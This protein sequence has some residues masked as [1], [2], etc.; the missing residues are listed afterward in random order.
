M[1][2]ISTVNTTPLPQPST[3][4]RHLR[5]ALCLNAAWNIVNFRSGLVRALMREG[6]EVVALAPPDDFVPQLLALGVAYVPITLD[7]KGTNP[8]LE[9]RSLLQLRSALREVKPDVYLGYTPKP[10]IYGAITCRS[11]GIPS[12]VNIAGLG[13]MFD[14]QGFRAR[15]MRF[16]YRLALQRCHLIFFQ[17]TDDKELFLRWKVAKPGVTAGLPGSGVDLA[18]FQHQP[19][20]PHR[21]PFIFL[22]VARLLWSKGLAELVEASR[23]LKAAGHAVECQV[24]GPIDHGSPDAVPESTIRAWHDEGLIRYLGSASDVRPHLTQAHA[25]VLPSYYKEGLPKTLLEAAAVGRPIITTNSVGCR[26]A[27][28]DGKTGYLCKP[29]NPADLA[30]AMTQLLSLEPPTLNAM[31]DAARH[32][33]ETIFDERIVI[34]RYLQAI[35]DMTG[36]RKQLSEG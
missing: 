23:Q 35:R 8:L 11:L 26:D 5:I 36:L 19:L 6:H 20:P 3:P 14:G 9:L 21:E 33:A 1:P 29:R 2:D 28:D 12:I 27:I 32:R 18:H 30:R 31:G 16:L 10:N 34:R 17:N 15:G 25:A 22:L 24:L 4:A 13:S 7:R